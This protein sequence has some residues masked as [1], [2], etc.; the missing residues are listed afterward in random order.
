MASD[1]AIAAECHLI[2]QEF[3]ATDMDGLNDW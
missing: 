2:A 1:P 3:A